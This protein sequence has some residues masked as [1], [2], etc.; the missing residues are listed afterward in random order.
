M[1]KQLSHLIKGVEQRVL[2]GEVLCLQGGVVAFELLQ[3]GVHDVQDG[4]LD[5][6]HSRGQ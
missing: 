2:E 4:A 1:E 6:P 5:G 3:A